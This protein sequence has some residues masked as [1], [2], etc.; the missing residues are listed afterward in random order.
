MFEI[1]N[2]DIDFGVSYPQDNFY[3]LSR[4]ISHSFV[5]FAKE[6][7]QHPVK[8]PRLFDSQLGSA[9]GSMLI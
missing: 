2:T 4:R 1:G 8:H 6:N 3:Q 9:D 7:Q 5:L